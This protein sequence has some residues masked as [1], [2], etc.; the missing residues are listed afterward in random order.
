[1]K[2]FSLATRILLL[3]MAIYY[4]IIWDIILLVGLAIMSYI[5]GSLFKFENNKIE[6]IFIKTILGLGCIGYFI[7]ISII[8]NFN[9]I[10]IYIIAIIMICLIRKKTI[11]EGLCCIKKYIKYNSNF[12]IESMINIALSAYLVISSYPVYNYDALVKHIPITLNLINRG[13]FPN[14]IIES[15]VYGE[16][17]L[18]R[19][20]YNYILMLLGGHKVIVLFEVFILVMILLGLLLILHRY[21]KNK[22]ADILLIGIY[23][24]TPLIVNRASTI[25]PDMLPIVFLVAITLLLTEIDYTQIISKVNIIALLCGFAVFSKLT[26]APYILTLAIVILFYIIKKMISTKE[27]VLVFRTC[28][29]GLVLFLSTTVPSA[30]IMYYYTG[31]PVFP[32][33]NGIFKSPYF[34]FKNFTD[35]F[36]TNPLNVSFRSLISMVFHTHRNIE[37]ADGGIGYYLLFLIISLALIFVYKNKSYIYY[38]IMVLVSYS[39]G[40]LFTSNIRYLLPS[41]IAAMILVVITIHH[42]SSLIKISQLRSIATLFIAFLLIMPNISYIKNNMCR[43]D[44]LIPNNDLTINKN[45]DL[46]SYVNHEDVRVLAY[47][48]EFKGEFKGEYYNFNWYNTYLN[49]KLLSGEIDP[50]DYIGS[51]DYFLYKKDSNNVIEEIRIMFDP[52]TSNIKDMLIPFSETDTHILYKVDKDKL[53]RKKLILEEN[54]KSEEIVTV[55]SPKTLKFNPIYNFYKIEINEEKEDKEMGSIYGRWQINWYDRDNNLVDLYIKTHEIKNGTDL[56]SSPIIKKPINADYGVLY[57]SSHGEYGIKIKSYKLYGIK[58]N[59][60]IEK[61]EKNFFDRTLLK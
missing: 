31:N 16:I 40:F 52:M 39:I 49:N 10:S 23:F 9:S 30:M 14:N 38:T 5:V 53:I 32:F 24:S 44:F 51:F 29:K 25:N 12:V 7:W 22:F 59:N 33:Y 4:N 27:Y 28:I 47:G 37:M 61:E 19:Y 15:L 3:I 55:A 2:K 54:F 60:I 46:L 41:H 18:L 20:T 35:P 48:D 42:I 56:Y 17:S 58:I 34:T 45:F 1:M 6:N 26:S 43:S 13:S 36:D 21:V 57:L 8:F 50:R 11:I